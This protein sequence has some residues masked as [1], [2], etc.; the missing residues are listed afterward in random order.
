MRAAL[1]CSDEG[2]VLSHP[3]FHYCIFFPPGS[4]PAVEPFRKGLTDLMGVCQ[5]VLN[6][7]EVRLLPEELGSVF[8]LLV[9][10]GKGGG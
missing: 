2:E 9:S 8:C 5:H 3:P 4:L 1:P 7:F 6:T 10:E